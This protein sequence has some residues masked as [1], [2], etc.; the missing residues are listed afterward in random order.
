MWLIALSK[1]RIVGLSF[2]FTFICFNAKGDLFAQPTDSDFRATIGPGVV[3]YTMVTESGP[4]RINMLEIENKKAKVGAE[5][6]LEKY[7]DLIKGK[8]I[9][10]VTNHSALLSNGKH[11]VDALFE[12]KDVQLVALFGPEHGIRGDAP[13]GKSIQ[14]GTDTKTGIPVYSLYGKINKPTAEMLKGVE[15]L[16]FDIQDIG[17]RFYTYSTTLILAMEAAAEHN[18]PYL[19]LDRPNPIR[20]IWVEGPIREEALKSFVGWLPVPVAHGLTAGELAT[21]ANDEGYLAN[22]VKADL[23]VI[24]M[25]GWKREKWYDETGLQW[26]KPSPNM[27][28]MRT[29]VVY[30]GTCFIEGTNVSEGRGTEKPFEYLGAPWISAEKLA[31]ELSVYHLPGVRFE[32]VAFTPKD[33]LNVTIDPKYENELCQGL[34]VNVTDRNVFA[35]VETGIY[36]LYALQKLFPDYFQIRNERLDRLVGVAYVREM[37]QAGKRPDEIIARWQDDLERFRERREKFLLYD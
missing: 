31:D 16:L 27:A 14:H 5:A 11:L 25:E 28:T 33:I 19:V 17:A 1:S 26:I 15:V 8:R 4:W 6:L 9:G 32:P 37:L 13:D 22:G 24:K 3:H 20:G 36:I 30:P 29:A 21:M 34:Y 23:T 18:M 35:P 2:V 10:L 12:R 7:F